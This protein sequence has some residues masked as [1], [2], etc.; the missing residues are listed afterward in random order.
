[1]LHA[2]FLQVDSNL[3]LL[4]GLKV[5]AKRLAVQ[6]KLVA[7]SESR[8]ANYELNMAEHDYEEARE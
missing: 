8:L 7:Q 2:F 6:S 5:V 4:T 3:H 1:M